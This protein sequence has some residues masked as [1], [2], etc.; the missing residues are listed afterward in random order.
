MSGIGERAASRVGQLHGRLAG[1]RPER[2]IGGQAHE[3]LGHRIGDLA[4]AVADG[5]V[6]EGRG[7]IDEAAPVGRLQPDALAGAHHELGVLD[8]VHVGEAVPEGSGHGR[9]VGRRPRPGRGRRGAPRRPPADA[10]AGAV[11]AAE[12][13]AAD[14]DGAWIQGGATLRRWRISQP[15][16]L[17][18]PGELAHGHIPGQP[19]QRSGRGQSDPGAATTRRLTRH[20]RPRTAA[21]QGS[22]RRRVGRPSRRTRCPG[23]RGVAATSRQLSGPPMRSTARLA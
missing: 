4:P 8:Q 15:G 21:A 19:G 2:R 7:R 5:A 3:L 13:R 20:S 23:R 12:R 9:M 6:P 17:A 1:V 10:R 22:R 11:P 16:R 14:V 18:E